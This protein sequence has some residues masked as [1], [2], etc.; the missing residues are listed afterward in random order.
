MSLK[1]YQQTQKKLASP[2]D[3]EYRLFA[4]ITSALI[5]SKDL[6]RTDQRLIAAIMQNRKLWSTL[7]IDC[8]DE[9]NRLPKELRAQIVSLSLWVSRYTS[10]V[11]SQKADMAPLIDINR[12]IMEGLAPRNEPASAAPPVAPGALA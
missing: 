11:M 12:T 5:G 10:S 7:A 2:R 4:E 8:A 3:T 1:A 9:A 6:P